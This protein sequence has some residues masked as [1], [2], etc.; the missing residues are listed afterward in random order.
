MTAYCT[1]AQ[2]EA[3]FGAVSDATIL[4]ECLDDATAAI[5]VALDE[6]GID[7][8]SPS[9]DFADRLMRV[10]RSMANRIMPTASIPGGVTQA[11]MTGGPYSQGWT[12]SAPYG[13]P[14]LLPSELKLLGITSGGLMSVP[15]AIDGYYGSNDD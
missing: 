6:A 15:A 11:T 5:N 10:C 9:A 12:F 13:T 4:G 1:K 7:Y 14:K 3:R 8:S 2:Y